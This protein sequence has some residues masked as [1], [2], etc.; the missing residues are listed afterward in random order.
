MNYRE[1]GVVNFFRQLF[2][3]F[4]ANYRSIF[5]LVKKSMPEHSYRV[6]SIEQD[7]NDN[8]F[9]VIQIRNKKEIFRMRPEEILS[10]DHM[11]DSFSQRDIRALT[12]L[13]YLGV[14]SPRYKILAKRLSENDTKLIFAIQERGKDKPIIKSA[15]EISTDEKI[16][17]GLHQKDAHMIGYVAATEQILEEEEQKNNILQLS[18]PFI[19][20]N[21]T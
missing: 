17:T 2:Y 4:S 16:I 21:K 14:N 18:E 19:T 10:N 6:L 3:K 1:A 20:K 5:A 11:T 12:Y 8:Y 7:E 15:H 9:A 13:G